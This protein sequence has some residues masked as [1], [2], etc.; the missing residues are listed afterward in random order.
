MAKPSLLDCVDAHVS[1][2]LIEAAI[3]QARARA[4]IDKDDLK[5][6]RKRLLHVLKEKPSSIRGEGAA[7]STGSGKAA[8][9]ATEGAKP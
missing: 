6:I 1:P 3:R 9:T 7:A 2:E 4:L 5:A 8:P